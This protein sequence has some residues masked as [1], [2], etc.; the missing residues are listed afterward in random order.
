MKKRIL[1]GLALLV[2]V[3]VLLTLLVLVPTRNDLVQARKT[4][5]GPLNRLTDERAEEAKQDIESALERLDG[6][7]AKVLGVVPVLGANLDAIEEVAEGIL[8]AI[9]AGL[10]LKTVADQVEEQGVLSEGRFQLDS[11]S[12]IEE[13]LK[14]QIETLTELEEALES[15]KTGSLW[16]TLWDTFTDL[17]YD[18]RTI[19]EDADSL[20][21]VL[22]IIGSLL[23]EDEPKTYLILLLNNAE[24]R[25]AG[26]ALT[27]VGTITA[28][29]GELKLGEF[30]SVHALRTTKHKLVKAPEDFERYNIYRANDTTLWINASYSPDV[31][32]SAKVAAGLYERVT[33]DE[34]DGAIA[35]DPRGI[36]A[37]MPGDAEI[38]VP[39][40]DET[41]DTDELADFVYSDAY[42][43][44]K[45]QQERRAAILEVGAE[46]FGEILDADL[47]DKDDLERVADA[48]AAGHIR[49][50]SFDDAE[51]KALNSA[52]A[53]G[54]VPQLKSDGV[55][56]AVQ[57]R[58]GAVGIGSK[59]DYW[60]D[61]TV[62][63]GCSLETDDQMKCTTRV[64]LVNKAPDGLPKYVTGSVEP[65]GLMRSIVEVYTPSSAE[66]LGA[67]RN[68]EPI[69]WIKGTEGGFSSHGIY[70]EIPQGA[71]STV[72]VVYN[73]PIEEDYSLVALPQPLARDATVELALGIPREW[74]VRGP[75][76]WEDGIYR[77]RGKFDKI[78]TVK[79]FPTERDGLSRVLGVTR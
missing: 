50:V 36:A 23:G 11:F 21:A 73:L 38:D 43:E 45:D 49:F 52:N 60:A 56:V 22:E 48:F 26:G 62:S 3:F 55:M 7:T 66:V 47:D 78:L 71:T 6:P 57:N 68:G 12:Q 8:P 19:R 59:M 44:F 64:L 30:S 69:G 51:L 34:M 27:G 33:G 37:L 25:G 74:T 29:N 18:V 76:R 67:A 72:E 24:L 75:G 35:V 13:P 41:I 40:I 14:K 16:P 15:Q 79:A 61:R 77:Y 4:L 39:V 2:S 42:E 5:G 20:Q 65:Y 28:D 17:H 10:E 1:V 54:S 63:H 70:V 58:G 9:D 31:V 46:A 53:T 32:D